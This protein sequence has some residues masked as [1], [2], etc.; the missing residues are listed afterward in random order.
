MKRGAFYEAGV[1]ADQGYCWSIPLGIKQINFY[2][3]IFGSARGYFF[4]DDTKSR[5]LA[6]LLAQ[7][8]WDER[9]GGK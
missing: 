2:Y 4:L 5:V 8:L 6:L 3:R 1:L 7:L 9:E